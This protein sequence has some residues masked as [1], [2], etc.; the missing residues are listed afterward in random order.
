[1][2]N[3]V[4]IGET[5]VQDRIWRWRRDRCEPDNVSHRKGTQVHLMHAIVCCRRVSCSPLERQFLTYKRTLDEDLVS[6]DSEELQLVL[7]RIKPEIDIVVKNTPPNT[8]KSLLPKDFQQIGC[9]EESTMVVI[10]SL[11]FNVMFFFMKDLI[12][13]QL[14]NM[15]PKRSYDFVSQIIL[16]E[17][18]A[19]ILVSLK[20]YATVTEAKQHLYPKEVAI[21]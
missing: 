1:L 12:V 8:I 7:R 3:G 9:V 2:S 20:K 19:R 6:L 15:F 5:K 17:V 10:L 18:V 4:A 13:S 21:T 14:V 16:P 11:L